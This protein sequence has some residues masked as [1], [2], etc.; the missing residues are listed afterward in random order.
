M[1]II[2][3]AMIS[4]IS[5]YTLEQSVLHTVKIEIE[6]KVRYGFDPICISCFEGSLV[7]EYQIVSKT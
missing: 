6:S 3:L 1:K 7:Q 2:E 4:N 5:M